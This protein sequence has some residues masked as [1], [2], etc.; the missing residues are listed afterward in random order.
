MSVRSKAI[1]ADENLIKDII[2]TL[3]EA[4]GDV[5][6]YSN[7]NTVAQADASNL[8]T[9]KVIGFIESKQ[10][11]TLCTVRIGGF[12]TSSGLTVGSR[13]FL[14]TTPGQMSVT[15]PTN[16]GNVVVK[17][18]T[19]KSTDSFHVEVASDLVIRA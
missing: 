9:S 3:T 18:G 5:V 8:S 1:V 4:V 7:S 2:C 10:S 11:D 17:V 12:I 6:Y 19:A 16:S 13:Y 15:P 14:S